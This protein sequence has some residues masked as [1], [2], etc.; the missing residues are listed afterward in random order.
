MRLTPEAY[1]ERDAAGELTS[2]KPKP[3]PDTRTALSSGMGACRDMAPTSFAL[4]FVVDDP[5]DEITAIAGRI[6]R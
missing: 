4:D 6:Y 2:G 1:P 5:E 3:E